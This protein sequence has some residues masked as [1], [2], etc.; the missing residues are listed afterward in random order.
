MQQ[1][2]TSIKDQSIDIFD[3][4][5][6]VS[7]TIFESINQREIE[8]SR[9]QEEILRSQQQNAQT[10]IYPTVN[11]IT[12]GSSITSMLS[13]NPLVLAATVVAAAAGI[14]MLAKD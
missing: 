9:I 10:T 8:E 4:I 6:N 5:L 12:G 1:Q 7:G 2:N 11:D 13:G 3:K 14:Y